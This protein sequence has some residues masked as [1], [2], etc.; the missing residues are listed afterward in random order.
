MA[1]FERLYGTLTVA[2][3]NI[4]IPI[5]KTGVTDF[6]VSADWTPASG[7]V[8]ITKDGGTPANVGTLPV[9]TANLGWEFVFTAAELQ[10]KQLTVLIVDS[11]TKAIDDQFFSIETYG[12]ASA[13]HHDIFDLQADITAILADTGTTLPATLAVIDGNVDDIETLLN[14]VDGKVDVIDTNVDDIETDTNE[15]QTDWTNGG[16]L[17]LLVDA[18]KAIT[19]QFVFTLAN[20]VDSNTLAIS[21]S[22]AQATKLKNAL[23][24]T[25]H[26]KVNATPASATA[27]LVKSLTN[28]TLADL[29]VADLLKDRVV[30]FTTGVAQ[31]HAV[32]I[33]AQAAS[34]SDPITLTT[35]T[36]V[37]YANI[38]AD[39]EFVI[40]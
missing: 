36:M 31:G 32:G 21:G 20:H 39:D 9:Y 38:A 17:D 35:T 5:V 26:G 16:R 14:T 18:I 24:G 27:L 37:N 22:V 2:A 1:A 28:D 33:S 15:L 4:Y 13:M 10:C 25:I 23:A 34:A 6:A 7:D 30:I 19:D 12:H 11:A 3:T 40:V 8:K 29:N